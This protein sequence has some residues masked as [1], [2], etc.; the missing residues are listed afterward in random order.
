MRPKPFG[1]EVLGVLAGMLGGWLL[2]MFVALSGDAGAGMVAGRGGL[3]ALAAISLVAAE[4]LFRVRPWC[5]HASL[6]LAAAICSSVLALCVR[7]GLGSVV[8]VE[9]IGVLL[10]FFIPILLYVR[11]EARLMA[12]RPARRPHPVPRH[13]P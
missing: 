9:L 12:P 3:A 2:I 7:L 13:V 4:A 8:A 6:C 11:G 5:Y 1:L 10:L